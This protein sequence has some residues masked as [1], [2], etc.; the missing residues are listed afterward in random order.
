MRVL[1][2]LL[3]L[4]FLLAIVLLVVG[5]TTPKQ[6]EVS[7]TIEMNAPVDKVFNQV[8]NLKNWEN[9]SPWYKM[10]P[11]MDLTY[12]NNPVGEN[13]WYKWKGEK[14]M[15]GQLTITKVVPNQR[16]ETAIDF[17][18]MGKSTGYWDFKSKGNTTEVTWGMKADAEGN[19]FAKAMMRLF[20]PM[21]MNKSFD[22]GLTNMKEVVGS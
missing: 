15:E 7:K 11:T 21:Q 22:D 17:K 5:L 16:I 20:F 13:S 14:T 8:N 18:E 1:K 10:E 4:L 12:S 2:I 6:L 19:P 3:G 9:W